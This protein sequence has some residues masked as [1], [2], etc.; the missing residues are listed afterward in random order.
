[1]GLDDEKREVTDDDL[2]FIV[3]IV[4]GLCNVSDF[5]GCK[6][7]VSVLFDSFR[8]IHILYPKAVY[9]KGAQL[10]RR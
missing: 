2:E 4:V 1:M 5:L 7:T 10:G 9:E 6:V 3:I 8:T